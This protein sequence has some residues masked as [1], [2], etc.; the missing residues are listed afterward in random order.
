[1]NASDL[2]AARVVSELGAVRGLRWTP[3]ESLA[4]A[5]QLRD[6]QQAL[7]TAAARI[8]TSATEPAGDFSPRWDGPR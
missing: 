5:R 7:R 3:D 2:E 8:D 1:V 4:I 6:T